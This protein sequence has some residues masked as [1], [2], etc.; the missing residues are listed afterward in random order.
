[1]SR[2]PH[3][4]LD[5]TAVFFTLGTF[6][7]SGSIYMLL[8]FGGIRSLALMTPLGG[9]FLIIAWILLFISTWFIK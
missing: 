5:L 9:S 3:G 2:Y 6:L 8:F 7:F 4:L 1:M